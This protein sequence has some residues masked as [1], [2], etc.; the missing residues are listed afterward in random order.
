MRPSGQCNLM[1]LQL[2]GAWM[3]SHCASAE[4]HRAAA[5]GRY[6]LQLRISA[7]YAFG[8]LS[9]LLSS[10]R[11]NVAKVAAGH[12]LFKSKLQLRIRAVEDRPIVK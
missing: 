1:G 12:R 8:G 2:G 11:L 10:G 6:V 7:K 4:R 5:E 3:S 9:D